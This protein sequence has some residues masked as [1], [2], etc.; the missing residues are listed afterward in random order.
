MNSGGLRLCAPQLGIAPG[1]NLGGAVYDREILKG[2]AQIGAI[3]DIPLPQGEA[4]APMRGWQIHRAAACR[5][6]TYEYNWLFLPT[7]LKLW[8]AGKVDLLRI[9]SP[10]LS[11]LGRFG[12]TALHCPVVAHLHH[13]EADQLIH[14]LLTRTAIHGYDLVTTDSEF[15]VRQLMATFGVPRE[16]LLIV[17]PGVDEKY[18]PMPAEGAALRRQLGLT[19]RL[20][21]LYLGALTPRKNLRFLLEVVRAVS[22]HVPTVHLLLAGSGP[23]ETE[24]RR[25][26]QELGVQERVSFTGYLAEADKVRYYNLADLF[27][28]PSLL[29]GFGMAV[30][31]AMACGV[32]VVSSN[33]ASLPEV[34]GEAGLLAAPTD[35]AGFAA[36][37]V[38]LLTD[39]AL[40]RSLGEA[41]RAHVRQHF[42]WQQAA[43]QT[44]AAYEQVVKQQQR[45]N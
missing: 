7:V 8:R 36:Q 28:F 10:S 37:I 9:H 45:R 43:Q 24:L 16:K 27:V 3:V 14:R 39:E 44:Y 17:Y 41:G 33:A 22:E 29:E 35:G 15:C 6:Y 30:A 20:L 32:P 1:S 5:R 21:L 42:S 38:R 18:Q 25:D 34:V 13:L 23:Q 31:E 4:F 12:K 40:R 2:L 11:L 26:A 19:D